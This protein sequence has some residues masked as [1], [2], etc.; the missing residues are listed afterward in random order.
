MPS[1]RHVLRGTS[2]SG[3]VGAALYL[4]NI[5]PGSNT[6][7][8][9][10]SQAADLTGSGDPMTTISPYRSVYIWRRTA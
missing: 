4:A 7:N 10:Y 5:V 1:H 8:N 9:A 3:G 2:T 6:T